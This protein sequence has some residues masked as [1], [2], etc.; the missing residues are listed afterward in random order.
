MRENLVSLPPSGFAIAIQFWGGDFH[1]AMRLARLL[2]DIQPERTP[3]VLAF[4]PR[5]DVAP[6]REE[7]DTFL[8][9]GRKFGVT[10]VENKRDGVDHPNGCNQLFAGVMDALSEGWR[11]GRTSYD[12]VFF[13]EADGVPLRRDWLALLQAEHARTIRGGKRITGD[14]VEG[15]GVRHVN[16]SMVCNLGLW[17]DRPSLHQTPSDQAHDLFHAAT[18]TAECRPTRLIANH[19]GSQGWS[20]EAL[21]GVAKYTAWA[22]NVKDDTAIAW[23][24]RT[25]V[26]RPAKLDPYRP[27]ARV[28]EHFGPCGI[29][30]G[31]DRCGAD[32]DVACDLTALGHQP[33]KLG[34]EE[35][36]PASGPRRIH[37][38]G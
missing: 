30:L 10:R 15:V 17:F 38:K 34:T 29:G 12:S 7:W 6:S 20:P 9:C 37:V 5:F 24:E 22:C 33:A 19:Y 23:A 3:T 26:D 4:C 2:A 13:V 21:A 14:L 36:T 32:A 28:H 18:L 16:G 35:P 25:L 27:E 11:A 1:Q 8:Y 31:C